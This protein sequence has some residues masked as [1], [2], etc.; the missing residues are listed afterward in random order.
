MEGLDRYA[1][2]WTKDSEEEKLKLSSR[3][4]PLTPLLRRAQCTIYMVQE[5]DT[6][7]KDSELAATLAQGK[8]VIAY[9]PRYKS[10]DLRTFY[11]T[12]IK[13]PMRYLRQRLLT[14]LADGFFDRPD[15]RDQ[16][17]SLLN[18]TLAN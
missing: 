9:I 8:P 14:L 10:E 1:Q 16:V 17:A 11:L 12:L 4:D 5:G 6:L 15:N 7:G 13:R 3:Q 18:R 2:A